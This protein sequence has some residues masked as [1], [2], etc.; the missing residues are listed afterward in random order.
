M[1]LRIDT[2]PGGYPVHVYECPRCD[3]SGRCDDAPING[4][5][6]RNGE[7]RDDECVCDECLAFV[8]K[9]DAEREAA[10]WRAFYGYSPATVESPC[11]PLAPGR[12][13]ARTRGPSEEQE[14][15]WAQIAF[16]RD[17]GP[18]TY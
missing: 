13:T 1:S 4:D 18:G 2:G 7:I 17:H 12:E 5:A 3:G 14:E 15:E 16:E 11:P 9:V 6:C 8:A 10:E